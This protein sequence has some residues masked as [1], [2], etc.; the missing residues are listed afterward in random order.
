MVNSSIEGEA[1]FEIIYEDRT[2]GWEPFYEIHMDDETK[3]LRFCLRANI[4]RAHLCEEWKDVSV[5]LFGESTQQYNEIPVLIPKHLQYMEEKKER[6][7]VIETNDSLGQMPPVPSMDCAT[8]YLL[9][10]VETTLTSDTSV[11]DDVVLEER[12]YDADMHTEIAA[13]FELPG[14]WTFPEVGNEMKIDIQRF[15]LPGIYRYYAVPKS[16]TNVYLT[17]ELEETD[18]EHILACRAD[19]YVKDVMIGSCMLDP[20]SAAHRYRLSLGK[21][22]KVYAA[23]KQT[24]NQHYVNRQ[25]KKR[26]DICEYRIILQN[27]KSRDLTIQAADQIPISDNSRITVVQEELSGG[28]YNRENGEV[29]WNVNVKAKSTAEIILRYSVI[30]TI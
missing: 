13:C 11:F 10:A 19:L 9:D 3:P 2:V 1:P 29:T 28:F 24:K 17:A 4:T 5:C 12:V 22:A 16:S 27:R 7:K 25:G 20:Q 21:D 23:R 8:S 26:K 30:Y 6:K 15:T 14:T 18:V